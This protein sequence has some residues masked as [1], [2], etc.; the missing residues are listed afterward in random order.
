MVVICSGGG[1]MKG[2]AVEV[3]SATRGE[4]YVVPV[5][6]RTWRNRKALYDAI[7]SR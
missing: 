7:Q 3:D 5:V 4:I 1:R 6:G 2:I